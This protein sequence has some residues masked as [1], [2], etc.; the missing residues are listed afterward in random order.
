M[1]APTNSV[2]LLFTTSITNNIIEL[3]NVV[4]KET[5]VL[6]KFE[7][8][9][10]CDVPLTISLK[11]DLGEQIAFQLENENL[12]DT[13]ETPLQSDDF[14]QV[15]QLLQSKYIERINH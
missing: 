9:S 8:V 12:V 13:S 3:K 2:P 15:C 11:S 7:I 10:L 4:L 5:F 14:N 6:K 1:T